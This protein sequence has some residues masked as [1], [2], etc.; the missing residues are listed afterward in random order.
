MG[1]S[2]WFTPSPT[3]PLDGCPNMALYKD[4]PE[5]SKVEPVV[6]EIRRTAG[7]QQL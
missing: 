5:R 4:L 3:M 6:R 7:R 1:A 2:S